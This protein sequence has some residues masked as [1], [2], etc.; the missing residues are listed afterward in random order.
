MS[1]PAVWER[2]NIKI[3]SDHA[4]ARARQR[5]AGQSITGQVLSDVYWVDAGACRVGI[6]N[7]ARTDSI[8]SAY[9]VVLATVRKPDTI[10]ATNQSSV[11]AELT[12]P[13]SSRGVNERPRR[14]R[15]RH[16]RWWTRSRRRRTSPAGLGASGQGSERLSR[17][18]GILTVD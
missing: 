5:S 2:Y 6:S 1:V 13:Y 17:A 3:R 7:P 12:V 8:F 16:G 10:L 14:R 15:R 9:A 4:R 18:R 11:V